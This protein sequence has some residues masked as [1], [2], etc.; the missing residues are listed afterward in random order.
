MSSNN[1]NRNN[2]LIIIVIPIKKSNADDLG[3]LAFSC[4]GVA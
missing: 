4:A 2:P 1:N 3:L